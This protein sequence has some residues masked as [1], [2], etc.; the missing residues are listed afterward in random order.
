MPILKVPVT[1]ED[2]IQGKDNASI[3]LVEYGDYQCPYCQKAYPIVKHLQ[4]HFGKQ[5][6]FVFRNFPMAEL[7]PYAQIAA[8]AAEYAASQGLFWEM[9]DLIYENQDRLDMS[10][11]V[12]LAQILKLSVEDFTFSIE[13]KIFEP[14]IKSDFLGGVRSGVNGTPTFF[15]N[16]ERH[17]GSFDFA[18]LVYA[19]D[20]VLAN[21]T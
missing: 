17:N 20:S 4:T 3:T 1:T 6:R 9:H 18:D 5:L 19:I 11:L 2:H 12:E 8:E 10:L 13:N 7:H 14:K 21:K 16:G 15:I